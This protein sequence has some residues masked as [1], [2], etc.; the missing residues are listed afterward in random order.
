MDQAVGLPTLNA[1][2]IDGTFFSFL[3]KKIKTQETYMAISFEQTDILASLEAL[4]DNEL[5]TLDF[6]VIGF[7]G[8]II[9]YCSPNQRCSS[10]NF[11]R[12]FG[13]TIKF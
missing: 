4:D 9:A 8:D 6:G 2:F 1:C 13:C 5:D 11:D 10:R 12:G 3:I 7:T